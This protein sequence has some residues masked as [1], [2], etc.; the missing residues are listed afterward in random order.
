MHTQQAFQQPV[1]ADDEVGGTCRLFSLL[2][3]ESHADG[4]F[5]DHRNIVAAVADSQ[6]GL[7]RVVFQAERDVALGGS[8]GAEK[9]SVWE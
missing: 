3:E 5:L 9:P 7:F 4:G 8:F 6:K 2:S 1:L